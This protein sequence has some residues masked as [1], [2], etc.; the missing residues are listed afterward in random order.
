[1][2]PANDYSILLG[3]EWAALNEEKRRPYTTAAKKLR[4]DYAAAVAKYE[5]SD[6][7]CSFKTTVKNQACADSLQEVKTT[8]PQL[9]VLC[10]EDSTALAQMGSRDTGGTTKK[11][12]LDSQL[13]VPV[14]GDDAPRAKRSR[15]ANKPLNRFQAAPAARDRRGDDV[16]DFT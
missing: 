4:A 9:P 1:M 8:A 13:S 6:A 16:V 10:E 3:K 11:R 14:P 12:P 5:R 7:A 15:R 2:L